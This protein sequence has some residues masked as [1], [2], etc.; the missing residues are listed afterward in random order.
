MHGCYDD[1]DAVPLKGLDQFREDKPI[2]SSMAK[3]SL[4]ERAPPESSLG[5]GALGDIVL[6][7]PILSVLL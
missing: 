6:L 4:P 7:S 5:K 2:N 1:D 3:G